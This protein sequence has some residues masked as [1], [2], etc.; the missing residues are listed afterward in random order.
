MTRIQLEKKLRSYWKSDL[1]KF[2]VVFPVGEAR[3]L[4]LLCLYNHLGLPISQDKMF[5]WINE[6]GG[7]YDR[8]ARHLGSDGWYLKSGNSRATRLEYDPQM[9]RDELMLFSIEEPNPI[10]IKQRKVAREYNLGKSDWDELLKLFSTRGC[11]VCGRVF[12]KYDKGHLN[13]ELSYNAENIVPM[14]VECNNWAGAHDVTFVLDTRNLI[15]RPIK[16]GF[17]S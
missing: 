10:W 15:A 11:A 3:L 14:C 4:A 13:P 8:Q 12:E 2:D 1:K 16:F 6:N 17:D 9:K 5:S 7:R